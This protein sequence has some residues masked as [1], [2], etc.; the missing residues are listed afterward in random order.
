MRGYLKMMNS[1]FSKR[2]DEVFTKPRLHYELS[3]LKPVP[4]D[5]D[6]VRRAIDRGDFFDSEPKQSF[7]IPKSSGEYR[8]IV[9]PSSKTK[10]IQRVL[11]NE[12]S[13]AIK[14]SDRSYAFRRGKS[15]LKAIG[16]V[17][18]ALKRF[19]HI[20]KVDIWHFF[21]T[22]DH[23]ILIKKLKKII[24]D[25]QIVHLIAYYLSQGSMEKNRWLDKSEGVY[26]GDVLSPLLS[27]IY[28]NDFDFYLEKKGIMHVR[29]SDD[30]LFFGSSKE[31]VSEYRKIAGEY[32]QPIKLKFNSKKTYLSNIDK[33]FEYLG[34]TFLGNTL[35]IDNVKLGRKI[36][37]L[38]E[39][40]LKLPLHLTIEK[41][42]QKVQGFKN[43]YAK[44]IQDETQLRLLQE[45]LN[46]VLVDKIVYAKQHKKLNSKEEIRKVMREALSYIEQNHKNWIERLLSRAYDKMAMQKP[47]ESAQKKVEKEK[48][49]YLQKQ[50]KSTEIV[51]S[52]F[53]AFVG[54]WQ[55]KIKIKLGGKVIAE[56]PIN[57]I[58][59]I[60]LL[61]KKSTI[62]TY[63]INECAKRKIDIDFIERST[64]YAMLTYHQHISPEVHM[65][66]LKL[67]FSARG[68]GYAKELIMSKAKNQINLVKYYN[69][70]RKNEVLFAKIE[71]MVNLYKK[72]K[73]AKD[74]K[75]LM[76]IEGSISV[77]YWGA[78]GTIIGVEDFIRTHQGSRDEINQ[79]INYAYAILYNRVQSALIHEGLNLYYPLLH[80]VQSNKPTLVYD[81]VEE[82]RQPVV[83]REII[84][85]LNRGKKLNQTNGLLSKPTI[86][87]IVQSVQDR[88]ATPTK[89][90]YG[91]SPL[92]NIISF[93][94]N[95][96][97]RSIMTKT[98]Y[99]GF[100]NRYN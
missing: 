78:F 53:G 96:L 71:I 39:Q 2:F 49:K 1:T 41:T 52:D 91:K 87:L 20:A 32:L 54:I 4:K 72:I 24:K 62:S 56:A 80:S 74:K 93:Q 57:R 46:E 35:S 12:L 33:G 26:Q 45:A 13:S 90:R 68:L 37:K 64:P 10:I 67:Y 42:N 14:F 15:P 44:L 65:E 95:Q 81:M 100:V 11:V 36:T 60:L 19:K 98:T 51:V 94:M 55:G 27:N 66:Q 40:T 28:L 17:R 7:F 38:K 79:A 69:R 3:Q 61:N 86:K 70:R 22:I 82:F 99:K 30:M 85:L 88:L 34:L 16:R 73:S 50:I 75:A 29:Y 8:K 21:D 58:K 77:Q 47:L 23:D 59:R 5:I 97:K 31:E 43:Y 48:R 9:V 25:E 76:G 18:D 83:D 89:S 6:E 84:S 63:L 92:Y